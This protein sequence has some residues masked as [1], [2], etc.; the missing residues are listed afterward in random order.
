M[1]ITPAL[2]IVLASLIWLP[3]SAARAAEIK[4]PWQSEWEKTVEAAKKEGKLVAAIPASAELRKAIGE[5]FPKR[6]PG[7]ELDLT[8]ARGPSN[9]AKIAAEHA[10]GVRD[11]DLLISGTSTPFNLLNAGILE[12]AEPLLILPEVKDPKRWF[13]GHVWLDNAKKFIYAFQVYQSEN[14]WHNAAMMKPEEARSY[15]D[16]LLP[17]FKGKIGILD[18]RSAGA[19]TATWAFFL[20][21]KGEE[22]LKKLAAQ[23]LFL[24]RDQRQLADSLAKG[25]VAVT[26]GLTYY[27]FSPF[28]KAGLPVKPLPDMKEG[29]Y[30]SC[31]SSAT[32]IV[33]NSPHPNATKVFINWLYGKEGQEIYGKAM[34]Q[35]TRRLDVDTK[36]M[37][38]HGVRASKDFLSVEENNRLENYGE[39]TV[40]KYWAA[41]V[42]I[43]EEVFK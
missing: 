22:W 40:G 5:V 10:A 18:P 14:I 4:A 24:S 35:A 34:G 2:M 8:N 21:I 17:K 42:K 41:S 1:R 3:T 33:K 37:A 31:G 12:P 29:T 26:I 7:I 43:A 11:F 13:G 25:K 16:L 39:E 15:D 32:S 23:D 38:A 20:K 36:W 19:G 9:A 30:T 28:L 27:T 6:Y